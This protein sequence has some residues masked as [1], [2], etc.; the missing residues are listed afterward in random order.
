MPVYN[1]ERFLAEAIR[2]VFCQE[3]RDL[4]LLVIDDGSSDGSVDIVNALAQKH[5]EI[6]LIRQAEH[7]G[8]AAA[9]NRALAGARGTFITFLDADDSMLPG[10]LSF[11]AGYMSEHP[12]TD[13]LINA[14]EAQLEP[15]VEPPLWLSDLPPLDQPYHYC[16]MTM[17]VRPSVFT[18]VGGFDPSYRVSS[19][20]NWLIRALAAGATVAKVDRVVTRRRVH[21]ANLTYH[22]SAE[23]R[24][25]TFRSL[26]DRI[27]RRRSAK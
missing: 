17:M 23:M 14:A 24:K 15:G 21:G 13:I 22:R 7:Q 25:A 26:R 16:L 4:E 10:R 3:I 27:A 6:R 11:Q 1:G 18:R 5:P 19:D 8:P 20:T 12:E 9:R 2:S